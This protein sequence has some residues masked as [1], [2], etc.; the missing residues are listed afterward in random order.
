MW[1]KLLAPCDSSFVI[2]TTYRLN[3]TKCWICFNPSQRKSC[4][5]GKEPSKHRG[6]PNPS[7]CKFIAYFDIK[8]PHKFQLKLNFERSL[9]LN[10]F[11]RAKRNDIQPT[12]TPRVCVCSHTS[13]HLETLAPCLHSLNIHQAATSFKFKSDSSERS[14]SKNKTRRKRKKKTGREKFFQ[15]RNSLKKT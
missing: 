11:I 13:H 15:R 6:K 12:F 9:E 2:R 7:Q 3:L 8:F 4:S 5:S 1:E 14:S 10:I